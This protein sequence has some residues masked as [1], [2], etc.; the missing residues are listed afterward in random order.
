MKKLL[1]LLL[2]FVSM[3]PVAG[4]TAGDGIPS[5]LRIGTAA[6][7]APLA[8]MKDGEFQ[9]VEADFAAEIT[10]RM[11]VNN[12]IV[13][14]PWE[15][16]ISALKDKRIDVIMGGMSITEGR[17][18]QVLFTD[19][20]M[21]VGQMALIRTSELV[22]WNRPGALLQDGARIGVIGGTTGEDFV[23]SDMPHV[24]LTDFKDTDSAVQA[25]LDKK[26]DVFIHDAPTIWRLTATS[27]TMNPDLFGMYRP[28]TE[29]YLAWAVRIQD[30]ALADAL[31]RE[32]ANMSKDG[33]LKRITRRWIPVTVKVGN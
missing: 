12:R 33:S 28:L 18:Q 21:E 6:N 14:L 24:A 13:V 26:I 27:T 15:E 23:R 1:G 32:L 22:Q 16:L 25:L 8:F 20:Y 9:G 7:Y 31:N 2:L 11:Q 29:E 10:R 30:K 3:V 19:P 5:I 4:Y 17:S